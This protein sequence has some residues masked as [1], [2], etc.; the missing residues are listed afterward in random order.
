MTSTT[1][2]DH[3]SHWPHVYKHGSG[4]VIITLHGYGGN[5][6]EVSGLADWLDASRPVL[7]PRGTIDEQGTYR[8]YGTFTG[9]Q[10]DPVDIHERANELMVFLR[11]SA[12]HYGFSL[13]DALV[14]GFSNGGAMAAALGALYPKEIR[15]VAVFSGVLPFHTLPD[16]DL[17]GVRVWSSHGKTD[18]WV[19][20]QAGKHLVSSLES[21]GA[22]VG[23]LVRQGG[24]GITEEEIT[25]ARDFFAGIG[26]S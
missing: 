21:L 13:S 3:L 1:L 12:N 18:M 14:S 2:P 15:Q 9:Q 25:G 19:S 16:T 8:W 17:T 26:S 11:H 6:V 20:E 7:S 24:H 22:M 23:S 4:P 5:E 10:F